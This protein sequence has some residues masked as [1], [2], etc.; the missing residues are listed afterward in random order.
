MRRIKKRHMLSLNCVFQLIVEAWELKNW[1]IHHV[2]DVRS[3][4]DLLA[5]AVIYLFFVRI[6][7]LLSNNLSFIE[8]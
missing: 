6:V 3:Q 1:Y 7:L 4:S 2:P 5:V 8:P